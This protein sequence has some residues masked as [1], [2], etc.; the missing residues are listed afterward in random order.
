MFCRLNKR[1]KGLSLFIQNIVLFA[2]TNRFTVAITQNLDGMAGFFQRHLAGTDNLRVV[3]I[4][5]LLLAFI[6]F[7]FL[8]VILYIKSLLNFIKNEG[9][10]MSHGHATRNISDDL[11]KERDLEK[12]L[13]KD[14]EKFQQ[15]QADQL[16]KQ[17]TRQDENKR[18]QEAEH[19][20][21][22]NS[23]LNKRKLRL[24]QASSQ[25]APVSAGNYRPKSTGITTP[26][27]NS[28]WRS[29][30]WKGGNTGELDEITAGIVPFEFQQEKQPLSQM[31]GLIL[32]ML[33]R[34]IDIG[35]I[36]QVVKNKCDDNVWEEDVI[37]L[38]DSLRNF[39]SLCNNG[40][41]SNLPDAEEMP[42]PEDALYDLAQNDPTYAL[43]LLQSLMNNAIDRSNNTKMLQKRDLAFLEASNYACIFGTL[44]ALNDPQMSLN[45][46][47]MAI[48]FSH[49][50]VNGWTRVGDMYVR[51]Q[52]DSKAIWAYQNALKIADE[53]H[54]M[55]QIA[56]ANKRLAQYYYDQ[57][58]TIQAAKL[59][60]TGND[61]YDSIGINRPL[62]NNEKEV[63]KIIESKQEDDVPETVNRLLKISAQR[64]RSYV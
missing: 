64:Q 29:F 3:S 57:G 20:L 25:N 49:K 24:V 51:T 33:G 22:K 7:L 15:R 2:V 9:E 62:T 31:P 21:E 16:R 30:D 8:V 27:T 48:E 26:R 10:A 28:Q 38:V 39:V 40:K 47:E 58:D 11:S 4:I 23:K 44:A 59:Y 37:Q 12:E 17:K 63:V 56:N 34:N 5:L 60:N 50:N 55:H 14:L 19:E 46:Y 42:T 43:H 35:K 13:A 41:F 45:S 61:Y 6:L 18:R 53:E 52:A 32:N 1:E 36:A 54:H